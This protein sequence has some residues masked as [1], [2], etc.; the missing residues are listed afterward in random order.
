MYNKR[1]KHNREISKQNWKTITQYMNY[2]G[3]VKLIDPRYTSSTCPMCGSRMKKFRKGQVVKCRRCG[4][5]LDRQLCGSINVYLRMRGF[6]PSPSIFYRVVIKKMIS[7][8][9]MQMRRGRGVTLKGCEPCDMALMN[10]EEP[11]GNVHQ[12]VCESI[13]THV[14]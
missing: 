14:H 5:V 2:K 12:G 11:E 10:P 8:W 4:L 1:R 3:K 9:K 13:K 7:L 6:P